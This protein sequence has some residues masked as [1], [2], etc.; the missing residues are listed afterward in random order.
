MTK[1]RGVLMRRVSTRIVLAVL[2][3]MTG[4]SLAE[5]QEYLGREYSVTDLGTLAGDTYSEGISINVW[6]HSL[7]DGV[8]SEITQ[9]SARQD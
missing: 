8:V 1:L 2:V 9:T 6:G 3:C 7:R 4:V 5:G